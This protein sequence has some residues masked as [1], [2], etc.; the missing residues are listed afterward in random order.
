MHAHLR[1]CTCGVDHLLEHAYG[2]ESSAFAHARSRLGGRTG[3]HRFFD[4]SPDVGVDTF[5][6]VES[7]LQHGTAYLLTIR[8]VAIRKLRTR[9]AQSYVFVGRTLA[10]RVHRQYDGFKARSF[11][12]LQ[13][14]ARKNRRRWDYPVNSVQSTCCR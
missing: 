12:G 10:D 8:E 7:A 13:H 11:G 3:E 6:V 1:A 5:P 4:T 2:L 9:I 14:R